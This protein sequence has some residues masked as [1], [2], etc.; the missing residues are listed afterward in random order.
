MMKLTKIGRICVCCFVTTIVIFLLILVGIIVA[1]VFL[2]QSG[3]E[4]KMGF[5]HHNVGLRSGI[6]IVCPYHPSVCYPFILKDYS[7]QG[8]QRLH[9]CKKLEVLKG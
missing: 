3:Y 1:Y 8:I 6:W 2:R 9:G 5:T 7:K 4:G